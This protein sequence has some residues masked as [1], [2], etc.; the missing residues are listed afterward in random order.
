MDPEIAP[1]PDEWTPPEKIEH[2]PGNKFASINQPTAG[3]RTNAPLPDTEKSVQL[4]SL[5]TPN[6]F[7]VS[8]LL[9]ELGIDYDAHKLILCNA[10]SSR[11]AF[12]K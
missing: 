2:L 11:R 12:V 1:R 7:K 5:G 8:I 4:Y 9:E 3:P 10:I 6:G